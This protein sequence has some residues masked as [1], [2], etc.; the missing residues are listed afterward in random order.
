MI[1]IRTLA[2]T[3]ALALFAAAC[4]EPAPAPVEPPAAPPTVL[5]GVD[6]AQPLRALGT[7]PFWAV[8]IT[9][10]ALVYSGLD[11][12]EQR[13]ANAGPQVIGTTAVYKAT[14]D[15]GQP[16]EVTLIATDCS[17]G[18][19]DRTYPLTARVVIGGETLSGC[20]A[21]VAGLAA[22]PEQGRVG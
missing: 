9:P 19:S 20:A 15:A 10:D 12:P 5:N 21:S 4:S 14:T 16:I 11:R 2:A 22:A 1:P 18:M 8:S 3:G 7:E 13:A 6:L 17:D